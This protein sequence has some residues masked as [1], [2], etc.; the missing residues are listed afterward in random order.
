MDSDTVSG[1]GLL[2]LFIVFCLVGSFMMINS[3]AGSRQEDGF[4]YG[5]IAGYGEGKA[6]L[7][8]RYEHKDYRNAK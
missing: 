3:Y 6:G 7:P 1:I 8:N 5:Y 2:I 4:G